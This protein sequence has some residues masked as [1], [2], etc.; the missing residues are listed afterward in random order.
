MI[1]DG[2][3][4]NKPIVT[5]DGR[6]LLPVAIWKTEG[7]SRVVA[8][9]D[10]G[11][12]FKLLGAANVPNPKDRNC[13]EHMLLER[14]DHMLW[15]LTRTRYGIGES[16][17]DA[18]GQTWSDV[19]PTSL[20]RT[21]SRFFLRR[22]NS[23]RVLLVRHTPPGDSVKRSHLTAWLSDD[24]GRT[25][26]GGLMLDDRNGVSYPDGI[27]TAEGRIYVIYDYNRL[28]EKQ[29]LMATFTEADILAGKLVDPK[30][31]LRVQINQATGVNPFP[32]G[33]PK[34]KKTAQ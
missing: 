19:V 29:I 27:Q 33:R 24:D 6:W 18:Q 31:R 15:M 34:P 13:D 11:Q 21:V 28:L 23:G 12:T 5:H 20:T 30:A 7:S 10:Q 2:I 8:S 22:L 16:M 26:Q 4:M 25:W 1:C 32:H 9:V 3:L 14:K 17:A